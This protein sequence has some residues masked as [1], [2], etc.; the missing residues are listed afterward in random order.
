VVTGRVVEVHGNRIKVELGEGVIAEANAGGQAKAE[1]MRAAEPARGDLSS[2]TAM[3]SAKWKQGG[4]PAAGST[5]SEA[6]TGQVRNFK[7][8]KLDAG[9]KRIELEPA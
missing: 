1:E 5:T 7:I 9:K 2:L 3:L 8:M 6:K 4:G